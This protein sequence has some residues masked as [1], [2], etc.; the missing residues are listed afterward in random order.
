[1]ANPGEQVS[2]CRGDEEG[3][4]MPLAHIERSANATKHVA[5][6]LIALYFVG[7]GSVRFPAAGAS[8]LALRRGGNASG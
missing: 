1:M 6:R 2:A 5:K 7:T 8:A 4:K 3:K